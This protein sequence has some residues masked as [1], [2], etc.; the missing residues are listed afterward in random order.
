DI[1]WY[2]RRLQRMSPAEMV[3]RLRAAAIQQAWRFIG[4]RG[5]AVGTVAWAGLPLAQ[6]SAALDSQSVKRLIAAADGV[7][8][9]RWN[10]FGHNFDTSTTDPD[11]HRD[12]R[13]G[14]RF[15]PM[16]YCFD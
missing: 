8:A 3:A 10:V 16:R 5:P 15:D 7:M 9:G 1:S 12:I 14:I 13:S 6:D 11:W 4:T 2:L